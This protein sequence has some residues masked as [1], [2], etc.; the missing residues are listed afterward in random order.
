MGRPIHMALTLVSKLIASLCG[1]LRLRLESLAYYFLRLETIGFGISLPYISY[2]DSVFPAVM[3]EL[4]VS[5]L[6]LE[7][8]Q[9]LNLYPRPLLTSRELVVL[10]G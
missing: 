9:R 5:L 1:K 6:P 3:T 10:R 7:E 4:C 8:V 2:T